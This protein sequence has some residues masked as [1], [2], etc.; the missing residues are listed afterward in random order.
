MAV[1]YP[2]NFTNKGLLVYLM[3]LYQW[4]MLNGDSYEINSHK[5]YFY[6]MKAYG[7]M[8]AQIHI[9]LT[10]AQLK[11]SASHAGHL[12]SKER[13]P[14]IHWIG[15]WVGPSASLDKVEKI[16]DPTGTITPTPPL[17]SPHPVAIQTMLSW[18]TLGVIILQV[19]GTIHGTILLKNLLLYS[20]QQFT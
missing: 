16:L 7:G 18:I 14:N 17:S 2:L 6:A 10:S 8:D 12:T 19:L 5:C 11:W 3:T 1:N 20:K 4:Y 9:F 13:A 15:G